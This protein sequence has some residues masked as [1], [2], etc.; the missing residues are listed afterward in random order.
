MIIRTLVT[1]LLLAFAGSV[2]AEL[3]LPI[4]PESP[5]R[6]YGIAD[7]LNQTSA[8]AVAQDADGFIWVGTFGG[9]NRFDGRDFDSYTVRQGLRHNLVQSLMVDSENRLW[10][11]DAAGGLTLIKHGRV[12]RTFDPPGEARG[13]VRSIVELD[14]MLYVGRQP[15]GLMSLPLN[16][17]DAGLE[18]IEGAPNELIRLLTRPEGGIYMI[19]ADGMYVF[20]PGA[21]PAIRSI[22]PGIRAATGTDNGQVIVGDKSGKIGWLTN[23]NVDWIDVRYTD[24]I[25]DIVVNGD[26]VEWVV[27]EDNGML[28]FGDEDAKQ[29]LPGGSLATKTT[30]YDAEGVLWVPTRMGL[31]RYLGSRFRHYPLEFEGTAPEVFAIL[32]GDQ[33]DFWFGTSLGLL[34]LDR[35]GLLS[36]VSDRLGFNRS[37]IRDLEFS[38]DRKTLWIAHTVAPTY[39]V[40]LTSMKVKNVIG[41]DN[42]IIMSLERDSSDKVWFGSY[43]GTLSAFDPATGQLR[44]HL[45]GEGAS[46]YATAIADDGYLWFGA[47]HH[48]LFRIDTTSPDAIPELVV[49]EDVFGRDFYTQL[50]VEG[51]GDSTTL[52]ISSIEGG[53]FRYR[54]GEVEQVISDSSIADYTIYSVQPLPDNTL[55]IVT[56]RGVF[57]YDL[58]SQALEQYTA[59]DGFTAIE[60]KVHA[61]FYAE[62]DMLM[63]GTT[64]GVTLMDVSIPMSGV[65]VPKPLITQRSVD[66][67]DVSSLDFASLDTAFNKVVIGFTAISTRNPAGVDF[68]YRLVGEDTEWSQ[69]AEAVAT[70]YSKLRPGDYRFEVRA[71][72]PGGAWSTPAAWSF[73]V[74]TPLWRTWWFLTLAI[75]AA[76]AITWALLRLRLRAV[77]RANSR[78]RIEVAERT[79]S[80]EAGRHQ[81]EHANK[82]LSKEILERQKADA[83]REEVE[84]R[85]QQAYQNSPIGMALVDPAG[86]VYSANPKMK[87]M[88][89][90]ESGNEPRKP[91]LDVVSDRERE[92]FSAYLTACGTGEPHE[93]SIEARCRASD[94][95]PR[96][97][98]FRPAAIHDGSGRLKHILLLANDI[99]ESRAMTDQ[100]EYQASFD[101]LTGLINRRAFA[102]RLEDIVA[103]STG[104]VD[105]FLMF[106]DLDQ[107]KIVN[108]TGGHAA[109]DNL[110]QKVARLLTDCVRNQDIVARLGGD[111]FGIIVVNCTQAVALQRAEQI[112]HQ[113]E[114]LEFPWEQEIL[115]IG[116]SIGVVPI[117]QGGRNLNELQQVADA[118][119]YAAKDAGRNRVHLVSGMEDAVHERRGEMRWVQ[120]LNNAIDNDGFVLFAQ[121]IA[122]L[123]DSAEPTERM[124]VLLRM[125]DRD[126]E[127]LIPPSEF[128]PAAERYGLQGRLDLWVVTKVIETLRQYDS[129][130]VARHKIWVNL[131]GGTVGDPRISSK[132][133]RLIEAASLPPGSINF[134]ITETAVIRNIDAA[135]N[136]IEGLQAKGCRFALDDF[137]SGLSS[138]GYLR[139]LKV[140]Y[141]KIDGQFVRDIVTNR[142]D[143]T[144]V[145]S[146]I[147]IA[148]S[149]NMRVVAEFVEDEDILHLIKELGSDAAQGYC[150][151]RPEPLDQLLLTTIPGDTP[152]KIVPIGDAASA[153]QDAKTTR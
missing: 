102:L 104:D 42:S 7:G 62:G 152:G 120:R 8:T 82:K 51:E 36:N 95:H 38:L 57:R 37:E 129:S 70:R 89:W 91:L 5:F 46:I 28:P 64:S 111:E 114:R 136:M 24:T 47:N 19:S 139:K 74:P 75:A 131:S 10:V 6:V 113:V 126:G 101:E 81:L 34:H 124:E 144:F 67:Q 30:V 20:E 141:L 121:R 132:F 117:A 41:D 52:W 98:D 146:I 49:S 142:N 9:L 151:H 59:L 32:P 123:F 133:I 103:E 119:C 61:N 66:D 90:P 2:R 118:A 55:V 78:L 80:I 73:S 137:G 147:D 33:E 109:G 45:I 122:P 94:G 71:R 149:L 79:Q 150:I 53:L 96:L 23:D 63:I 3:D 127:G 115:R 72:L 39:G 125:R 128:L 106:L 116:V 97:I 27:I 105:A 153:R 69:T 31:A 14:D 12:L 88:F 85:F 84:T 93:S 68:S 15:G 110:L 48:G 87:E 16:D 25:G 99:T 83:L 44:V 76:L 11:G 21:I 148:H 40:D 22:A 108:D 77:A 138:F 107:F 4:T 56:N 58:I 13:D 54:N 60:G 140:D 135:T 145:K 86:L 17:M 130:E 65:G 1:L 35:N 143:R 112:R 43:I 26:K 92:T 18:E 29:M 50:I 100:L 134:E